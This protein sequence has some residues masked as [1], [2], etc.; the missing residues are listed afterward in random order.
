[1]SD[2]YYRHRPRQPIPPVSDQAL[3]EKYHKE[4]SDML[5]QSREI[6]DVMLSSQRRL[7]FALSCLVPKQLLTQC[8][9]DEHDQSSEGVENNAQAVNVSL[10]M[11]DVFDIVHAINVLAMA[12][13]D[14]IHVFTEFS[15]QYNNYRLAAYDTCE[16][17]MKVLLVVQVEMSASD[18]LEQ[19]LSIESQLTELI[20]EAREE[21]EA[22]VKS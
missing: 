14:V 16:L 21:A 6:H 11:R 3:A 4:A 18:I 1:M 2:Q 15:G 22:G 12:N 10:D 19:L 9:F 5:R 7:T 20:I 13:T 17:P 8:G